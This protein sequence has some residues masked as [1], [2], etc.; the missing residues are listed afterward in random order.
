MNGKSGMYVHE[1]TN[2]ECPKR[3]LKCPKR[4]LECPKRHLECP[5][6]I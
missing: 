5:K 1:R 4:H 2:V 6:G 3:H